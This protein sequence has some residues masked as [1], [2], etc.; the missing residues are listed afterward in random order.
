MYFSYYQDDWNTCL[1]LAKFSRNNSDHSSTKQSPF[2]TFYGRDP[3]F[4]S[5]H[6][7]QD[8]PSGNLSTKIH[9][10]QQDFKREIEVAI[11][12]LR[13]YA[14]KSRE[15]PPV[16]N[17]GDIVWLS[18]KNIK[19]ARPIKKLSE[20][21]LGPFL[22]LKKAST[23]IYSLKLPSQWESI[24]PVFHISLLEP[25]KTSRASSSNYNLIRREMGSFSN[26]GL[27]DQEREIMVFGGME[28]FQSRPRKIHLGTN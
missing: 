20:R 19:S 7:T 1:P 22:I 21:W 13:R 5:V 10:V 16:F 6:I 9:S 25:V 27:K 23:H 17:P 3:H 24:H 12:R 26:T 14:D 4:Y 18:S 2:F 11:N 8:T 28:R 15:S